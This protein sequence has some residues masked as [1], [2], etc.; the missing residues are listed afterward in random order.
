MFRRKFFLGWALL[1]STSFL[2]ANTAFASQQ[3]QK[4][5]E[6]KQTEAKQS[7]DKQS[8]DKQIGDDDKFYH[9]KGINDLNAIGNRNVGCNRGLGNWYTLDTQVKMGQQFAQQVEA[10][11]HLITDPV[12]N[13][14]VN[15]L[16]QN[17]SRNSDTK[18]P[19]TIKVL[20]VEEPNAFAQP[21]FFTFRFF[22]QRSGDQWFAV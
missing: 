17:L 21:G 9:G 5:P 13:E 8:Q 20:D 18:L 19:F 2:F 6:D 10:T 4:D 14:Y 22:T 7:K 15:R 3:E 12:V 16:G 1:L 11:S